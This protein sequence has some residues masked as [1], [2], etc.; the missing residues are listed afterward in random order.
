M[1]ELVQMSW[2]VAVKRFGTQPVLQRGVVTEGNR[3]DI[4]FRSGPRPWRRALP[5]IA[6]SAGVW[7]AICQLILTPAIGS[8]PRLATEIALLLW[9]LGAAIA[10]AGGA[11]VRLP[12]SRLVLQAQRDRLEVIRPATG[13]LRWIR[14][15]RGDVSVREEDVDGDGRI[16]LRTHYRSGRMLSREILNPVALEVLEN[17]R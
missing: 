9:G 3:Q 2:D 8:Y 15:R 17:G 10:F 14:F 13:D 5:T 16:D 12:R 11:I 6:I 7:L 4:T 1:F